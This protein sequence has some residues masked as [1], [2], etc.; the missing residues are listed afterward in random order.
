[1]YQGDHFITEGIILEVSEKANKS[2]NWR[3]CMLAARYERV[4]GNSTKRLRLIRI[5]D[6]EE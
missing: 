4:C 1:L 5:D 6:D 3:W 2:L